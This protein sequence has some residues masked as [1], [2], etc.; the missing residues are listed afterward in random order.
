MEVSLCVVLGFI[1]FLVG[2][3]LCVYS[4]FPPPP[5]KCYPVKD[6]LLKLQREVSD[7]WQAVGSWSDSVRGV[8]VYIK[9]GISS[10]E[11]S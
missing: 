1:H 8:Y 5:N 7:N 3:Q 9:T 6:F 4:P 11:C 10:A 2:R